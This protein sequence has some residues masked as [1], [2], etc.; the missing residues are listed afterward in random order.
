MHKK[1]TKCHQTAKDLALNLTYK[2]LCRRLYLDFSKYLSDEDYN[3]LQQ[4]GAAIEE[5]VKYMGRRLEEYK[6]SRVA[7]GGC[8]G[9]AHSI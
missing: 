6:A 2:E 9:S 3:R 1:T 8:L 4:P 7:L 5:T